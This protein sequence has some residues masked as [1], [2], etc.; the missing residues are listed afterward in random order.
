MLSSSFLLGARWP[1]DRTFRVRALAGAL[2]YLL[3]CPSPGGLL[4]PAT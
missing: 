4:G 3:Q 1:S 2:R